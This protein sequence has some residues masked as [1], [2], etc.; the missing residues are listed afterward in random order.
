MPKIEK[1]SYLKTELNADAVEWC[2]IAGFHKIVV[3]AL[4]ELEANTNTDLIGKNEANEDV[5]LTA[6]ECSS[7]Q[8]RKG[9]LNVYELRDD[10][11]LVEQSNIYTS[12]ILDCKWSSR[13]IAGTICLAAA[14]ATGCLLLFKFDEE[15]KSL[16]ALS[17]LNLSQGSLILS[18]DWSN[19]LATSSEDFQLVASDSAGYVHLVKLNDFDL[20]LSSTLKSHDFEAWITAFDCFN[21]N[22]FYTGGDDALL[23]IY[24][25]RATVSKA[26]S[27]VKEHSAGVTSVQNNWKREFTLLTGSYD[28]RVVFWDTRTMKRPM[29]DVKLPGGVWRIKHDPFDGSLIAC[30]CMYGGSVVLDGATCSIL[31][32]YDFHENINYGMDWCCEKW[33]DCYLLGV[34]SFYDNLL[35]LATLKYECL[36]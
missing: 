18:L 9:S 3:C 24:D 27:T 4:Y 2:P 36:R 29:T 16:T 7:K 22:V 32:T 33:K 8:Y 26:I 28:E 23:K 34:C 35:S 1:L 11:T 14:N 5:S 6:G 30:P 17:E 31:A 21:S 12:G 13:R 25:S 20:V 15:R 19:R 10:G